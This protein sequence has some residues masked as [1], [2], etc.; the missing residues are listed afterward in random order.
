MSLDEYDK[1]TGFT[2]IEALVGVFLLAVISLGI[3]ATYAFGLKMSTQNRMRTEATAV[4][5]KKIEAIRAMHYDDIGV[6]GGIPPGPLLATETETDNGTPYTIRTNIRYIDDSLDYTFPQDPAPTDYKQVEIRVD[7]PTNMERR[8]ILNTLISPPRIETNMGTG[9]LIINT[10]DSSGIPIAD[11]QVHIKNDQVAPEINLTEET[12][13]NGSLILPGAPASS[14]NSYE[15]TLYKDGYEGARTYPPYPISFFNPIDAHV[16]VG[17]GAITSKV[18][19]IDLL[20]YQNLHFT[21]IHGI[22]LSNLTFSLV[23]GKIIGTTVEPAPQ[24]VY[25][26]NE[27]ALKSDTD[28]CWKSSAI[29]KGPYAFSISDPAYELITTSLSSPWSIP[30][31]S[32]T[33]IEIVMGDKT[34]N[35]LVVSVKET[36]GE[37]PIVDAAVKILDSTGA[38]FQESISDINGIAYFPKSENP[39]KSFVPGEN[40]TIEASKESYVTGQ[41][42][43]PISGIT[44]KQV[45]LAKQ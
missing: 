38:L 45:I 12:D 4:A 40:Y 14:S 5:E 28:G 15:V 30:P 33:D 31:N 17:E 23:G 29:G 20:S 25:F 44:R 43:S 7:W 37:T 9:V 42:I 34:E 19:A 18:F 32:T 39:S 35:I 27:N 10:V 13:N 36:G 3:Y 11:C 6:Q 1:E 16:S 24:P 2:M 26:F 21:D 8:V 22:N 41:E